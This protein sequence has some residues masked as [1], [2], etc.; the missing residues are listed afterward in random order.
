MFLIYKVNF[1]IYVFDPLTNFFSHVYR[2]VKQTWLNRP[3]RR[4]VISTSVP[5]VTLV[6]VATLASNSVHISASCIMSFRFLCRFFMVPW[7]FGF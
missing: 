7:I 1:E 3:I 2:P 4:G 5:S 6:P